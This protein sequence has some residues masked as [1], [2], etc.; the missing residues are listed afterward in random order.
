METAEGVTIKF[1]RGTVTSCVLVRAF[2]LGEWVEKR[3]KRH[4]CFVPSLNLCGLP[5]TEDGAGLSVKLRTAA[6]GTL[7]QITKVVLEVEAHQQIQVIQVYI[8]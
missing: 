6:I 3:N 8:H 2:L 7:K 4:L 1:T 5:E